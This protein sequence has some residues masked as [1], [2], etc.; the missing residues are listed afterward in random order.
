MDP[1]YKLT[2]GNLNVKYDLDFVDKVLESFGVKAET[3][4]RRYLLDL[5]YSKPVSA[6]LL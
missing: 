1:K 3:E 5:S 4:A 6:T 2:E